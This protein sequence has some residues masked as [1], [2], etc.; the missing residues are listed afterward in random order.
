MMCIHNQMTKMKKDTG[1][2]EESDTHDDG[3]DNKDP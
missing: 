3:D 1:K 2:Y